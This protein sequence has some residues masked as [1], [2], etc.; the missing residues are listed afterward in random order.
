MSEGRRVQPEWLYQFLLT[1]QPIR[2]AAVLQMPQFPLSADEARR[3][4]D[5]FA[6]TAGIDSPYLAPDP[7]RI[8]AAST[9]AAMRQKKLDQAMAILTDQRIYCAKCHFVGDKKPAGEYHMVQAPNLAEAGRRIRP[10][11]LRRW[12]AD[13]KS[14]IPYTP[15]PVNFPPTGEPLTRDLMP[16]S[17]QEQL[18]AVIDLLV[19]YDWYLGHRASTPRPTS[20][21]PTPAAPV[22]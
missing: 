10:D 13:P 4:A 21:E 14:V 5:Y 19:N 6:A 2:P 8:A 15:M 22:R 9:V 20:V 7:L 1:P 16:G 18:D 12:L 11:Y 3:L 17:S